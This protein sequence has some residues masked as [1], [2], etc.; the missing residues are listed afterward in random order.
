MTGEPAP[1]TPFRLPDP[2]DVLARVA[3]A[4]GDLVGAAQ[5]V[6]LGRPGLIALLAVCVVLVL[7]PTRRVALRVSRAVLAR[8]RWR[9]AMDGVRIAAF[10]GGRAR[11]RRVRSVPAGES[12][13]VRVPRGGRVADL[14][15]AKDRIAA[16]LGAREVRVIQEPGNAGRATVLVVRRDPLAHGAPLRWPKVDAAQLSLWDPIPV[17][18]DE[19]GADVA[20]LLPERNV[21]LGGE[22]GAGKSGG[23][24]IFVATAAL[25]PAVRLWL[26]DGK[27]VELAGWAGCAERSVGVDVSE[28]IEVLSRLR[29]EMEERYR[30]LLTA[31]RRKVGRED[32]LPLHVVVCDELAHYLHAGD[33][34]QR[35][36]FAD[37]LRDLVSRGRAAGIVVLAATQKPSA[38]V[39]PTALR[40][41][42]GFRWAFRCSTPQ[43]SDTILGSGWASA[44]YSASTID[45]ACR[46]VGFLLHEGGRPRRLRAYYLHDRDVA[47]IAGRAEAARATN[48]GEF[49]VAGR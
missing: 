2:E 3:G 4:L 21:L 5:R 49:Q 48:A 46:G 32:G 44:G 6:V 41:L 30:T 38:D 33:R 29:D 47:A 26:L 9:R 42:F 15:D 39:I 10:G 43:A 25:D 17:G 28:A 40:D 18:V 31:R 24:A 36:E 7:G 8:W 23:L 35:S 37:V 45:S 1:E 11:V 27:I 20:V 22:P 14:D 16:V 34:K 12:L 13:V 19:D